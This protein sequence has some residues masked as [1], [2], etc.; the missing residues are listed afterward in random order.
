M[1]FFKSILICALLAG[2]SAG[3]VLTGLQTLKVYPLIFAAEV[4]EPAEH[5]H[6]EPDSTQASLSEDSNA[7]HDHSEHS[8]G[9][10]EGTEVDVSNSHDTDHHAASESGTWLPDDGGERLFFS[11]QSNLLVGV[12]LGLIL[13]ALFSVCDVTDWR[14]GVMWG[15]AGFVTVNLA[16]SLGL[17]PELPGMPAAD[18]LT[19]Q[20]WWWATVI[21]TG[22]GL[23][24]IFKNP[25]VIWRAAGVILIAAPHIYGAP[26]P[27]SIESDVPAVLAADFATATFALN[28]IFWVILGALAA[29]VMAHR[30]KQDGIT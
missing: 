10:H 2:V 11:L 12:G 17:P 21:A 18:L 19:R 15:V 4:Y 9:D 27:D 28:L 30:N 22:C 16:P 23:A 6:S 3:I 7:E 5:S 8:H 20:F 29:T 24:M 1:H 13:S 25:E 14:Q 26:H